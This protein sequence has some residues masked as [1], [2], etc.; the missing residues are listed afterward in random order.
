MKSRGDHREVYDLYGVVSQPRQGFEKA[1]CVLRINQYWY[2]FQNEKV[3]LVMEDS[4]RY[5]EP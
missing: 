5:V 3:F 1:F 4:L 2:K